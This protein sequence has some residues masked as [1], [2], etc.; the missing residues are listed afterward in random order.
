MIVSLNHLILC[1]LIS[2]SLQKPQNFLSLV[3]EGWFL[4]NY[5]LDSLHIRLIDPEINGQSKGFDDGLAIHNGGLPLI[6]Q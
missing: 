1:F 2:G 4:L 3:T 5:Y 6:G